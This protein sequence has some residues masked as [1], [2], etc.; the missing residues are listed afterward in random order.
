MKKTI[1]ALLLLLPLLCGCTLFDVSYEIQDSYETIEKDIPLLYSV[2]DCTY[3]KSDGSG[4]ALTNDRK[5]NGFREAYGLGTCHTLSGKQTVVLFFVDDAESSWSAEDVTD[6]TEMRIFPALAFLEEEAERWGVELSF[7]VKRFSTPLSGGLKM[8]YTGTV[9][10]DLDVGGAT[11][12]I[13][14]QMASR[15]GCESPMALL[16][17]MMEDF[18]SDSVI[19]VMILQKGGVAYTRYHY[20]EGMDGFVEHIVLF[21]D[22]LNSSE[23][24]WRKTTRRSATVA[25]QILC[26]FGGESMFATEKRQAMAEEYYPYDI[27]LTQ[28]KHLSV[29]EVGDYTAYCVGWTDTMPPICRKASWYAP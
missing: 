22:T 7:E 28:Y 13:P 2:E 1:A 14:H 19:P 26:M 10:R 18:E 25:S 12:D 4:T 6:F 16:G 11:K 17:A 24:Q 20:Y 8:Q 5:L 3:L 15:L 9:N 29:L 27:M 21:T 23:G